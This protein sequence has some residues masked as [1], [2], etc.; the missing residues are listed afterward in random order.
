V[1]PRLY[2]SVSRHGLPGAT[3]VISVPERT[4]RYRVLI[5]DDE[6]SLR[7]LGKTVLESQGYEVHCAEDGFEG[8]AALKRAFTRHDYLG[9]ADAEY[10]WL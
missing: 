1:V 7:L 2:E 9:S 10:E 5:V 8:L 4:F 6:A 3:T